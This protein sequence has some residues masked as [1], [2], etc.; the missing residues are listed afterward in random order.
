MN[1][2]K[3]KDDLSTRKKKGR[4]GRHFWKG[5]FFFFLFFFFSFFQFFLFYFIII[6]FP[7]CLSSST[8]KTFL[9][10]DISFFLFSYFILLLFFFLFVRVLVGRHF[11]KGIF[12]FS[13][14]PI[15][16]YILFYYYSFSF[17]FEF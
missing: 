7:F 12:L 3:G 9:E 10:G 2:G 8:Q 11:W 15:L 13:F 5:I 1:N 6:L 14:F 17:L 16:F 4:L